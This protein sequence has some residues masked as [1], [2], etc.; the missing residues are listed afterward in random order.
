M[1]CDNKDFVCICE[2]DKYYHQETHQCFNQKTFKQQCSKDDECLVK[3]N[4]K[5][6]ND[7]CSC[8]NSTYTWDSD[9]KSCKYTYNIIC[10]NE[11]DCSKSSKLKCKD[12]TERCMCPSDK[13]GKICDCE[14][15]KEF[16][17]GFNCVKKKSFGHSCQNSFEC[18]DELVCLDNN[19]R[20]EFYQ[21]KEG[22]DKCKNECYVDTLYYNGKCYC[23]TNETK[24]ASDSEEYCKKSKPCSNKDF[25][26]ANIKN[27][28]IET[29]FTQYLRHLGSEEAYWIKYDGDFKNFRINKFNSD[30]QE[31][32]NLR[33]ICEKNK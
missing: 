26:I 30:I 10:I 23:F 6:L 7:E 32:I 15:N 19:C 5:C 25:N 8:E 4:L 13:S 21:K 33:I 11:N 2:T 9:L 12:Y 18:N 20:C 28:N 1:I 14:R 27:I 3:E 17:N 16:W 24:M 22:G 31:H 29:E